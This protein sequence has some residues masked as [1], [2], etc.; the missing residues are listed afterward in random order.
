M[1]IIKSTK[2]FEDFLAKHCKLVAADLATKHRLMAWGEFPFLRATFYRW[3]QLFPVVCP[4]LAAAP[5]VL[6]V[7]DLHVENFG[8]WR[9]AD[10][11]LVWGIN[12]FDEACR[13]PYANDLV[14]L[15]LSAMLA[16]EAGRLEMDRHGVCEAILSGYIHTI[17]GAGE[18]FVLAEHHAWLG[19]LVPGALKTPDEYWDHLQQLPAMQKKPPAG[20]VA[21]INSLMP[22]RKVDCR[23]A[24][25][26]AGLGSL[27]KIRIVALANWRGSIIAREAKAITPSAWPWAQGKN[28]EKLFYAMILKRAVRSP[29]PWVGVRGKWIVRR[30]APDCGRVELAS[31]AKTVQAERLLNAMGRETA[32]IHLGT[33]KVVKA[34]QEDL[35]ERKIGWLARAT[36]A[37]SEALRE[38]WKVWKEACS[39]I[40]PVR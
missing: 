28:S 16:I 5:R 20:A 30:L 15:A 14:R 21:A 17:A 38:D 7:G 2:R 25:R 34:I 23:Y 18:P 4:K 22:E 31:L 10:G 13:L 1:N 35:K 32:N 40:S 12:D 37:M 33:P 39:D 8:T 27:G 26:V 36:A 19:A 6:G 29:D 24:Q 11:R 9:D 3:A